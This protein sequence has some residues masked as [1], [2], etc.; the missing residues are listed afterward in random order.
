MTQI[1]L[2]QKQH[3]SQE[4]FQILKMVFQKRLFDQSD[5]ILDLCNEAQIQLHYKDNL[6]HV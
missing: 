5:L 3:K 4:A 1:L 6:N 2:V